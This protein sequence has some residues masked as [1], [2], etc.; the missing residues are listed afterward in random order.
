MQ[1]VGAQLGAALAGSPVMTVTREG[2]V[3]TAQPA[4]NQLSRF[5]P[6][7]RVRV[8]LADG[9]AVDG[10]IRSLIRGSGSGSG[11][12]G[13]GGGSGEGQGQGQGGAKT[14][15]TIVLDAQEQAQRA[16]QSTVSITVVGDTA[17]HALIVPVTALLALDGGGYGV[18]VSDGPTPRL[19]KVQLGLIADAKAQITGDV[20]P[21]A[22]VVIPK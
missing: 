1:Q 7:G 22:Q 20:R 21:G 3:V 6:D 2:L 13:E 16:G 10:R 8:K 11:S 14:T 15:V 19:V 17:E 5:K 12:G 4:E 9:S 18:R